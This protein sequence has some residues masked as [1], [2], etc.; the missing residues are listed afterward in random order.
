MAPIRETR[1]SNATGFFVCGE[2]LHRALSENR[3]RTTQS[4]PA[5]TRQGRPNTCVVAILHHALSANIQSMTWNK[6]AAT[7]QGRPNTC[8]V[9]ILHRAL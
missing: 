3:Q 2:I 4:K 1:C 6:P 9:A 5:A 8:V 7:R